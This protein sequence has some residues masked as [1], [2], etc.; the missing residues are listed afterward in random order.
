MQETYYIVYKA[1]DDPI[2]TLNGQTL[3]T[4]T[5][6]KETITIELED[7]NEII[8]ERSNLAIIRQTVY[9]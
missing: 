3:N 4:K 7:G 8:L 9:F 6:D 2:I 5:F 1:P